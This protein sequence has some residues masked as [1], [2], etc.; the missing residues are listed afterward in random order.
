M[1]FNFLTAIKNVAPWLAGTFGTPLAGL[2]VKAICDAL[3]DPGIAKSV[4]DAHAAD[5]LGG[6]IATLGDL[7]QQGKIAIADIQKAELAHAETM[8][9]LGYKNVSDLEKIAADDRADARRRQ[10]ELKDKTPAHLAYLIIL[11]FFAYSG[12]LLY[13]LI[14]MP[15]TV[16]KI[17]AQGWVIIGTVYGYL[18]AEAKQAGAY[19]FGTTAGSLGKDVTLAE[20]AKS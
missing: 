15:D 3:P 13:A 6:A 4:Q 10:V 1:S 7:L 2:A 14:W 17:P 11:G 9:Q 8:A 12:L 19:F 20:I 16:A 18:A 5:P